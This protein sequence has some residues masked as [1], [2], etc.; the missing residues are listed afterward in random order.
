[1]PRKLLI[2][3]AEYPYHIISRSRNRDWYELPMK[4]MWQISIDS[5]KFALGKYEVHIHAFVLMSNHYH[6]LVST[7]EANIDLFM[8]EFNRKFSEL[9]RKYSNRI[10]QIFGGRYKWS[11]VQNE[12]YLSTVYRYIY[13]NPCHVGIVEKVEDYPYSS[14]RVF[15]FPFRIYDLLDAP[16]SQQLDFFNT[17]SEKDERVFVSKGLK[18]KYFAPPINRDSRSEE[19]LPVLIA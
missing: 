6:L 8:F 16:F 10:N 12:R 1:M 7:P 3:T 4:L 14:L 13:R 2:R 19:V 18:K 9:V 5:F 11:L 17:A 15:D